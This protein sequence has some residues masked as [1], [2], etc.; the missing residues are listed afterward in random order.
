M[1][2]EVAGWANDFYVEYDVYNA[3]EQV[4]FEGSGS[5]GFRCW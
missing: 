5:L 4:N 3:C 2:R 1:R